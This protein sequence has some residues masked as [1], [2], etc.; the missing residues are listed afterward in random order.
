MA[1]DFTYHMYGTLGYRLS[2]EQVQRFLSRLSCRNTSILL[3]PERFVTLQTRLGA[4]TKSSY[5]FTMLSL[6]TIYYFI[7]LHLSLA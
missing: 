6:C 7:H 3:D 2:L 5:D 4:K 1:S